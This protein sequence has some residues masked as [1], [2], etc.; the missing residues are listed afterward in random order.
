MEWSKIKDLDD[1]MSLFLY[2]K[3][4]NSNNMHHGMVGEFPLLSEKTTF[5]NAKNEI[6]VNN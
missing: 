1:E 5:S 3:N 4:L 2:N 6:K